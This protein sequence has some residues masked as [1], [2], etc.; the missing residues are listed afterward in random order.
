[1]SQIEGDFQRGDMIA[2]INQDQQILGR[3]LVTFD[4]SDAIKVL[5]RKS[6]EIASILGF[7][8]KP[9]I[10]HRDDMVLEAAVLHD[11]DTN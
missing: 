10:I 5:G 7:D 6:S 1:M 2:I 8:R 9:E 3:G 11:A 4:A